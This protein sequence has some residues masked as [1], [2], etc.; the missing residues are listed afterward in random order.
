M[1]GAHFANSRRKS[2]ALHNVDGNPLLS[3]S[4][5][6]TSNGT[7]RPSRAKKQPR[8]DFP[9][10]DWLAIGNHLFTIGSLLYFLMNFS[11]FALGDDINSNIS[12]GIMN[13][14]F[15]NLGLVFVLSSAAYWVDILLFP[16]RRQTTLCYVE[17]SLR[18]PY[19]NLT[20]SLR[21][22]TRLP[23]SLEASPVLPSDQARGGACG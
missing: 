2:N 20:F 8:N 5:S 11:R 10:L 22:L 1:P 13:A 3:P 15:V 18:I 23:G 4:E 14:M 16:V 6:F 12:I 9:L 21:S 17:R 19:A 7:P